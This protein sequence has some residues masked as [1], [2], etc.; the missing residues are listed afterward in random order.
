MVDSV[1]AHQTP[2]TPYFEANKAARGIRNPFPKTPSTIEARSVARRAPA[3]VP[4]D[5][6]E[7]STTARR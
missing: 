7:G 5:G 1:M 6:A 4:P 2:F 3:V